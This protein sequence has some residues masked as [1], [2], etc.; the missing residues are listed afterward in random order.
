[1][2]IEIYGRS[3]KVPVPLE[4]E[5]GN[6]HGNSVTEEEEEETLFVNGIVTVGA[7]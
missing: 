3:L 1:M 6:K 2:H 5:T 7:V 4:F